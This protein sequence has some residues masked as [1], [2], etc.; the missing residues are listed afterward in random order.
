MSVL[1]HYF[2]TLQKNYRMKADIKLIF[3]LSLCIVFYENFLI[4]PIYL[5][6]Y[7]HSIKSR[8]K[9]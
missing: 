5:L 2:N 6:Y 3:F 1:L 4:L 8:K 7:T 9:K